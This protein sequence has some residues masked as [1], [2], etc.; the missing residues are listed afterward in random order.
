[1]ISPEFYGEGF[2]V[3][4]KNKSDMIYV[5]V[6]HVQAVTNK[7]LGRQNK[8]KKILNKLLSDWRKRL[9]IREKKL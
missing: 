3:E 2:W 4:R 1:M 7:H 9:E 6:F 8:K 5:S